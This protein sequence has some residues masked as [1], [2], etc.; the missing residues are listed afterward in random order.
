[1][2]LYYS[3]GACSLSPHIVMRELNLAFELERVDSSTRKTESGVD[4]LT[5]NPSGYVPALRLDNGEILTEG[6]AVVQFLADQ[7]ADSKLAPRAG[8]MERARLQEHLNFIASELHKAFGPLFKP[9]S[10]EAAKRDAVANVAQRFERF[11]NIL[12]DGRL[13]LMGEQFSVADA[14][15]FVVSG[16]A[17]PTGIGLDKWPKLRAF[18]ERVAARKAVQAALRAEGLN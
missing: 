6:A 10:T 3:P 18:G 1:M 15:L 5:V 12:K 2:K 14:Y 8:T 13:Y 11:E 9:D 4:F 17:I 16:W 7:Y